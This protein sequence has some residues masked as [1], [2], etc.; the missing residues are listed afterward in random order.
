MN[1]VVVEIIWS[2]VEDYYT[3]LNGGTISRYFIVKN[4]GT[5]AYRILEEF[6]IN[7]Q[8]TVELNGVDQI[9]WFRHG[10]SNR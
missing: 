8:G 7:G 2:T 9:G 5:S 1:K 3:A 6:R 4:N 10:L